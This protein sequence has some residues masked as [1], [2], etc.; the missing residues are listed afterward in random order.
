MEVS[1]REEVR[2][3]GAS[4]QRSRNRLRES[5]ENIKRIRWAGFRAG[6]IRDRSQPHKDL[7]PNWDGL[8]A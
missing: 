2:E 8:K 1:L 3:L 4:L 6:E 7:E 5:E